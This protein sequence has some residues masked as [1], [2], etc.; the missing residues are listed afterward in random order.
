MYYLLTRENALHEDDPDRRLRLLC[1]AYRP[2]IEITTLEDTEGN[3]GT[4]RSLGAA[5]A[6]EGGGS[7]KEELK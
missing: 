7:F 3:R 1:T 5:L 4:L 2:A 6:Q